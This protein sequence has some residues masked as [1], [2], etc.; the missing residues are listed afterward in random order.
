[1]TIAAG[2]VCMDGIV[3]CADTQEVIAGYTKNETEKI[4]EYKDQGLCIAITGAGD[5]ELIETAGQLIENAL[6]EEY[7]EQEAR[8]AD[9]CRKI[10][11]NT[12]IGFLNTSIKP[13]ATF[14]RDDRPSMPEFLVV[15]GVSNDVNKYQSLFKT[16]GT[17]VR[18]IQPGGECIGAGVM[19]ARSFIERFYDPFVGL[20]ELI[21]ITCYIMYHTKRWTD[22]CGGN[23][24]MVVSSVKN[25]FFGG[26]LSTADIRSLEDA[27]QEFDEQTAY[28][29][30]SLA[31]SSQSQFNKRLKAIREELVEIRRKVAAAEALVRFRAKGSLPPK[32]S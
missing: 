10:I 14:P 30:R 2:F 11:E 21:L 25:D 18:E 1:V 7:S 3:L 29:L 27:F 13:W 17:T 9:D 19:I 23:T 20:D 8:F 15:I 12:L 26:V 4:R 31:N 5:T 32:P 6:T 16:S 24:D 22:G 28:M